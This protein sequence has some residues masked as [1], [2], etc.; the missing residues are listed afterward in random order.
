MRPNGFPDS[1]R[2]RD[3]INSGHP[4]RVERR[5]PRQTIPQRR[6]QPS[7]FPSHSNVTQ[8]GRGSVL[9]SEMATAASETAPVPTNRR[10]L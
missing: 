10:R 9:Y 2:G 4:S 6:R 1:I 8:F 7:S 5:R 3:G